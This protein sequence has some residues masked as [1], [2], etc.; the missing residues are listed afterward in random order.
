MIQSKRIY[1]AADKDDGTR[2]LVERLW[3]RGVKKADAQLDLWLKEVAPSHE[4]RRW[5]GHDPER[6]DA[7]RRRY[8]DEL[9]ENDAAVERLLELAADGNLTL[10]YAARDQPGNSAQVLAEYLR[11]RFAE[12]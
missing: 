12:K 7:F 11:S 1:E 9:G 6:W 3:P 5:F 2:V 10:L 8:E 4:L